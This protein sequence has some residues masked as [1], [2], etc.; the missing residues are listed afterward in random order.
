MMQDDEGQMAGHTITSFFASG[1]SVS[2]NVLWMKESIFNPHTLRSENM[3]KKHRTLHR[4]QF[5]M[6]KQSLWWEVCV[7]RG[8]APWGE[9]RYIYCMCMWNIWIISTGYF[10]PQLQIKIYSRKN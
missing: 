2:H 6:V 10:V 7:L 3:N 5:I 9:G 4:T 8:M 1:V